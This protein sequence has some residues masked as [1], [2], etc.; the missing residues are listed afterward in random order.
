MLSRFQYETTTES[1]KSPKQ[2]L[3]Y[4]LVEFILEVSFYF[5]VC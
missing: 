4:L 2:F 5:S 1:K 3:T